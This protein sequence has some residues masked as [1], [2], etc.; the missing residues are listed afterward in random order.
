MTAHDVTRRFKPGDRVRVR[1]DDPAG[2]VRTPRY[3]RGKP[4]VIER[5]CGA[6]NN[7]EDLAYG[8]SGLPRQPLYRVRFLQCEVWPDYTG[9]RE[10]SL[11]IEVFQHWLQPLTSTSNGGYP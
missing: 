5:Y 11:D 2:H 10:D 7:P 4:G 9:Y 1:D 8:G 6:F 3:I